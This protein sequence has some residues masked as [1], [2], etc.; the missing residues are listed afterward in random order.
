MAEAIEKIKDV[1]LAEELSS[2]YLSYAMSTIVDRC[3][4]YTS[5]AADD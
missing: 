4:L 1:H 5:D 2:R 3:L